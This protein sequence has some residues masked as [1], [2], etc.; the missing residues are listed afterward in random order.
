M[1][2]LQ[3]TLIIFIVVTTQVAIFVLIAFYRQWL[4]FVNVKKQLNNMESNQEEEKPS[5]GL[6]VLP[7]TPPWDGFRDLRVQRK[8]YEDSNK[9]IC[10]FYLTPLDENTLPTFKPGQYLTFKLSVEDKITQTL[11]SIVRCYSLSDKPNQE[12]YRVTIKKI[13]SP[14]DALSLPPGISSNFF[15]EE[16]HEG[17]IL[18]VKAPAGHFYLDEDDNIPIVLIGGGIGITP[19]LSMLNASIHNTLQREIWLYYGV[20]NSDD[21]I[22][23]DYLDVLAHNHKNLHLHICYSRPKEQD[24]KKTDYQHS[25]HIDINL[26]RLTLLLKPFQFYVCGPRKMMETLIPDLQAWGIPDHNIH[27]ESFGPA[28]IIKHEKQQTT[29]TTETTMS[30]PTVSFSK[31]GQTY[32]W[33]SDADSLL[34]FAEENGIAVDSGCRAGSCG[35]CK[36]VIETGELEYNQLPDADL[37]SGTC[38]LCISVPKTNLTLSI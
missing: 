26:L 4:S 9:T 37:E 19:L 15:H 34:E 32:Q 12:Y 1:T 20:H 11:K 2:T 30:T 21:H 28:S 35:T 31:S 27:Y 17:D 16:V 24:V 25:G 18:T 8:N 14:A 36:T 33:D 6:E 23:K 5:P 13:P 29:S 22:M 3:L 38:L 10:S 7:I